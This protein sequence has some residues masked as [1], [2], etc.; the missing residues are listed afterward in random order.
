MPQD[1]PLS[2]EVAELMAKA[3]AADQ[4]DIPDGMSVP[5]ELARRQRCG[6][7]SQR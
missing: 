3:E 6:S 7:G 4:V 2:G 5:D 1:Q